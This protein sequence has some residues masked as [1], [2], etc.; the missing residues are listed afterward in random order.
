MTNPEN[1][2][3]AEIDARLAELDGARAKIEHRVASTV[4]T[5][6]RY[7]EG[8]LARGASYRLTLTEAI[9]AGPEH[10]YDGQRFAS[11]VASLD[12]Y[13][14]E[15]RPIVDEIVELDSIF[16]SVGGWTRFFLVPGGHVHSGMNCSTCNN[17]KTATV[18]GWLPA[19]SGKTEA[20][21]VAEHG[22][23]LCSV[24]YPSAPV[25]WTNYYE[26]EAA[27]KKSASCSGSGTYNYPKETARLGYYRGNSGVCSD[28]G[29][30]VTVT[31]TEKLRSHKP[32]G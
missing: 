9:E 5:I 4:S 28:C 27:A 25:E 8:R 17:G 11:L 30:R 3:P 13:R 6:H 20:D 19:L 21:A 18:F 10:A 23:L 32:K 2:I 1:I 12:E 7:A 16:R 15:L 14:S 31:A 26:L 24:C 22:A 29:Q